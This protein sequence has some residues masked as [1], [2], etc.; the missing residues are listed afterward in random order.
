M[1]SLLVILTWCSCWI[2]SLDAGSKWTQG[3]QLPCFIKL[4]L[5]PL[6]LVFSQLEEPLSLALGTEPF[7]SSLDLGDS[8]GLSSRLQS[9]FPSLAPI[10][11]D[12]ML[13]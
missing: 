10:F 12:I 6:Q 4:Q 2:L 9:L 3:P 1:P 8:P 5:Q 13:S 11:L 7:H